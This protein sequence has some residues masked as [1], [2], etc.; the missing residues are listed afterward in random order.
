MTAGELKEAIAN[1]EKAT[2]LYR[3][4]VTLAP[5]HLP[6]LASSLLNLASIL[7][8]V[9]C[10]EEAIAACEEAVSIMQKVV[11]M[12][13]Y[14]LPALADALDQLAGYLMEKGD[15]IS[16]SAATTESTEAQGKYVSL[17]PG[18]DFLFEKIGMQSDDEDDEE[19]EGAWE[20]ALEGD[21]E[22][23]DVP[24]DTD[25]VISDA[26]HFENPVSAYM[27]NTPT[28]S[29]AALEEPEGPAATD[30]VLVAKG[31]LTEILSKP[32]E[33]RLSMNMSMSMNASTSISAA[34]SS[35]VAQ[36]G[37]EKLDTATVQRAMSS[38]AEI[39]HT[40]LEIRLRSTPVDGHPL[41]D[42]ARALP[43]DV[44]TS[45]SAPLCRCLRC[46]APPG[47]ARV[48][49]LLSLSVLSAQRHH[50][51]SLLRSAP[52]EFPFPPP[53][54][55]LPNSLALSPAPV[56]PLR[57]DA[58]AQTPRVRPLRASHRRQTPEGR[59]ALAT[60]DSLWD[61]SVV[62]TS[63]ASHRASQRRRRRGG[64]DLR[65]VLIGVDVGERRA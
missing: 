55:S 20:T 3:E 2:E 39:L 40:P 62:L 35:Q 16:A 53:L 22:Y 32:L 38:V 24:M 18:P 63:L 26:T 43:D 10:R 4:L 36:K 19:E 6:T 15:I 8:N 14:F 46:S 1:A 60:R 50:A 7:W 9:S 54:P 29:F 28:S 17:P 61:P 49:D 47:P 45:A 30:T 56:P 21:D 42:A 11:E 31:S 64:E 51:P 44:R 48:P 33:V 5:Q 57:A 52:V 58:H 34:P 12:E 13:T 37:E 59:V 25:V 65:V 27:D 41:V 23:C